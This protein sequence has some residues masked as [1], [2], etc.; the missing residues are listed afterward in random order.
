L[1]YW[2]NDDF[3]DNFVDDNESID[4]KR[5]KFCARL[6]F[7]IYSMATSNVTT[8]YASS[9]LLDKQTEKFCIKKKTDKLLNIFA[10][11][12]N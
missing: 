2:I 12:N 4:D 6:K 11:F 5:F 7:L 9:F 8:E 1:L 10:C 3:S